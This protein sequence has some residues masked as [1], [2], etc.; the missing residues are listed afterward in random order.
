[1]LWLRDLLWKSYSIGLFRKYH[2][3]LCLAPQILHKHCFQFLLGLSMVPRENKNN[4]YARFGGT[5][6]EYC[7]IFPKWPISLLGG[8]KKIL[9]ITTVS[10]PS[11]VPM[12]W[13]F[14]SYLH[15]FL[16]YFFSL[17]CIFYHFIYCYLC[18]GTIFYKCFWVW[19]SLV[20]WFITL[21]LN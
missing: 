6:K 15:L 21:Y 13:K 10:N 3:T 17:C 12:W 14:G 11:I 20:G 16:F 2:N 4:A 19:V 7:C 8:E 1:L 18:L 5:N 9:S